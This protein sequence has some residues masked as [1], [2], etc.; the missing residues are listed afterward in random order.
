[1]TEILNPKTMTHIQGITY[2]N[3]AKRYGTPLYIYDTAIIE[4]QYLELRAAFA[5]VSRL[6]IH[7]ACKALTNIS[8]LKYVHSLG[9]YVDTVSI[10][11]VHLC[12]LAGFS[13]AQIGYTPSGVDFSEIEQ[14]VALGVKVHLDSLPLMRQFGERYGSSVAV[15]IRINPNVMAGG[16]LKISTGHV[17]SKFGISILQLEEILQAIEDTNLIV[18]TLH[19]H[20]GS[21]I[22][23]AQTF[24]EVAELIFDAAKYFKYLEYI[25]LGGG[26]K[27]PYLPDEK[28]TDMAAMGALISAR[29]HDFCRSYGRELTLVFE[30]GKYLVSEAGRF[31]VQTNVVKHNPEISFVGVNSG[32]NHLIRPMFYDAYHHIENVTNPDAEPRKYNIVGYICETDNFAE[33]RYVSEIRAGDLLC[34]HNAGAYGMTMASNYNSRFRPAEVLIHEGKDYLIRERET[35]EDIL[36]HQIKIDF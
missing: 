22:K 25:D 23:A 17:R 9:A 15:G 34:F 1:M 3:L 19:Q 18:N 32:L 12:L 7:Y 4:K 20:T 26:F 16:N 5:D 11:E 6:N 28:G 29:F 21:E 14:A 33:D 2:V 24:L 10:E 36:R 13:A 27:V 31:L 30:P 8:I 35:M